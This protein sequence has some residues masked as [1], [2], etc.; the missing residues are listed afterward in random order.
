MGAPVVK[1]RGWREREGKNHNMH[2]SMQDDTINRKM[3]ERERGGEGERER[4]SST[5]KPLTMQDRKY[6]CIQHGHGF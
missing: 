2:S 6:T 4:N 3:R 5:V 1:Y